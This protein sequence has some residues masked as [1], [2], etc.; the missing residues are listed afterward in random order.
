MSKQLVIVESPAKARTI[1]KF[2]GDDYTI[3]ASVGHI[4]DLPANASEIPKAFKK[5]KWAR[6][7]IDVEEDFKALYVVPAEKKAQIKKLKALL[8]DADVLYLATDEDRE[9]EA[10][11][12]HL[13]EV[14]NP[15]VEVKRLVFHEITKDA[16]QHALDNTRELDTD[17]IEAQET[18]RLVDRL[19]GYSVSPLLWKKVRPKLSAG[20]VQSV[21]VRLVVEREQERMR[22]VPAGYW[23]LEGAFEHETAAPFRA[24]LSSVDGA[25]VASG[26]DFDADT[27][28]LKDDVKNSVLHLDKEAAA[29]LSDG[30]KGKL[31]RVTSRERKPYTEK[32]S[33]PFTTSTLQ[34]AASGKLRL[35][36]RNTMRA[37]Q[38]LYEN[39]YITYMR[40]DSTTLSR[41]AITGAR[42][43]VEREFGAQYLPDKP[44][45]YATKVKNAQEAHEA[46]RPAGSEFRPP[47]KLG[48]DMGSDE[49][50]LYDLIYKRTV[51]CQMAD[52]R[53][54]RTTLAIEATA[55]DGRRALFQTSGRTVEFDGFRRVYAQEVS[56]KEAKEG[57]RILPALQEGDEVN[58]AAVDA[59]DH[60]TQPP[61]RLSE[62]SLIKEMEARGIGRP[63]TYASII[64]TIL[65]REYVFK[66]GSALV[67]TWTA[68][69]VVRLLSENLPH[70]VDYTFT[71]SMENDLDE[72]SN[73]RAQRLAYLK[74][75]YLGNGRPGL[76]EQL[77]G[78]E[79]KVDARTV[80]TIVLGE[81][82]DGE[83]VN[84]RVGRYGPYIEKGEQRA[85]VPDETPPDELTLALALEL[86]AKSGD[87][88]KSLGIDPDTGLEVTV[89]IGRFGPYFQLGDTEA[90]GGEKPKNASLLAGM[91]PETVLLPEA[92]ATLALPRI[93]GVQVTASTD[94]TPGTEENVLAANGRYGPYLKWGKETRS[95]PADESPLT[96]TLDKALE[97]LRTPKARRGQ[98]SSQ[99]ILKELGD[100]PDSGV[101]V[102]VLEGRYGPYVTDGSV[103]ASLPK[104]KSPDELGMAEAVELLE[105][106]AAKAKKKP[107]RKKAAKKKTAKK[108]TKKKST[109]K[110]TKKKTTTKKVTA[111][112][113]AKKSDD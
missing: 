43:L 59:T 70:L 88:P 67:P 42:N 40:T 11:S 6:L 85:S 25:R 38:R 45:A 87:G 95:L 57:D 46:I 22:F 82:D 23:S 61:A 28:K 79:G 110:A 15:K 7:G 76:S 26:R 80:C 92:L 108:A 105:A 97:I 74:S 96:V 102:K 13:V 104:G 107:A 58:L 62:A 34:Q 50:R 54:H 47:E 3:E 16:I 78:L 64:E 20:R 90:L 113:A 103:N 73:G 31:A 39:G 4:R 89:K 68:F 93:V 21:A 41:E 69:A 14:L 112:K 12:W 81:S 24:G 2:L 29:A 5:E 65:A 101:L 84:V 111:K 33:A 72:I 17:L 86:L 98:S 106:R 36:P 37:A 109:K 9:G 19:Y 51:A 63:S 52:A 32:P 75:F 10:I 55:D 60:T 44:R 99:K 56:E 100:H 53:G 35:T 83:K 77:E 94:D 66:K 1:G 91:D 30:L 71:A 27:G 18:R 48:A 49:R 8:K